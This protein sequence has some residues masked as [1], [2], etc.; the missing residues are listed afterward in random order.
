MQGKRRASPEEASATARPDRD[1]F[2]TQDDPARFLTQDTA[3]DETT[4]CA[5]GHNQ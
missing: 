4:T 1:P 2:A 5:V 3:A